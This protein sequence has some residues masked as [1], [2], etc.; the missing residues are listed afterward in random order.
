MQQRYKHS[1]M[2]A[3]LRGRL[4]FLAP[5]LFLL[6]CDWV[7]SR[8]RA[9]RALELE[10]SPVNFPKVESNNGEAFTAPLEHQEKQR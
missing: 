6:K 3:F 10:D 4:I 1:V 2:S 9:R 5:G 7:A 8:F